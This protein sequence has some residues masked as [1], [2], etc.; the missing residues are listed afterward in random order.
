[1][2]IGRSPN[3]ARDVTPK[4]NRPYGDSQYLKLNPISPTYREEKEEVDAK[5]CGG[6][7]KYV[8]IGIVYIA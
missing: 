4:E 2:I 3:R 6:H 1:M 8:N 5:R 7:G